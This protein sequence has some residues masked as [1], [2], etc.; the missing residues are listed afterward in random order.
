MSDP[1]N[2]LALTAALAAHKQTAIDLGDRIDVL[3]NK[4]DEA[5]R[6]EA[7]ALMVQQTEVKRAAR[8]IEQ[9]IRQNT[10]QD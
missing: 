3:L 4:P 5:A 8:E 1:L 9:Q 2:A 10:Q 7:R 6:A